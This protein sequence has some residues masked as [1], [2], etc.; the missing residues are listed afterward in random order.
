MGRSGGRSRERAED[1]RCECR[2]G[3]EVGSTGV[4]EEECT[5]VR[6]EGCTGVRGEECTGVRE[7]G[8]E[9]RSEEVRVVLG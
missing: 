8:R 9:V 3:R 4:R 2:E 1:L 5:G 7:E 6:G